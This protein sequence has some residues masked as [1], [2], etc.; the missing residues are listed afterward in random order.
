MQ[1][2]DDDR[3]PGQV[4]GVGEGVVV[5][6]VLLVDREQHLLHGGVARLDDVAEAR[7]RV[8]REVVG[9]G[10]DERQ[11]AGAQALEQGRRVEQ[12]PFAGLRGSPTI[13]V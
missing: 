11:A 10:D 8:G 3:H 6:A 1:V 5:R 2:G 13:A 12:H 4:V 9:A 7:R